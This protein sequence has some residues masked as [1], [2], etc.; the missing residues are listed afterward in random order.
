MQSTA[1]TDAGPGKR[2][3]TARMHMSAAGPWFTPGRVPS[4]WIAHAGTVSASRVG[5]GRGTLG[6][7]P[8]LELPPLFLPF[9]SQ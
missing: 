4:C 8:G 1:A 2:L 7:M 9:H 6:P 3:K 5:C